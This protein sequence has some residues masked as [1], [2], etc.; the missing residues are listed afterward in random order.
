MTKLTTCIGLAIGLSAAASLARAND[1]EFG[2][3]GGASLAGFSGLD[4]AFFGETQP[5]KRIGLAVGGFVA[6]PIGGRFAL[7][8]E[9]LFAQKGAN[10]D[11]SDADSELRLDY[12]EVPL[13]L[14]ARFG[15]GGVRPYAFAGPYVGFRTKAEAYFDAGPDDGTGTEDIGDDIKSVDYGAA[16]GAGLEIPSGRGAFLA[17]GR[18]TRGLTNFGAGDVD[19]DET[20]AHAVWSVL[21]GFRF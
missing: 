15:G 21:L 6:L 4:E 14:K 1:I 8:P 2:I 12:V 5:T 10:F 16:V 13:L 18:Y 7:Q 11:F 9:A 17:E 3:K 20:V 19:S